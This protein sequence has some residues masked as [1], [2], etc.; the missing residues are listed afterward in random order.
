M[1]KRLAAILLNVLLLLGGLPVF[2]QDE[3]DMTVLETAA[4]VDDSLPARSAILIEQSSGRVLFEK[5]ADEILPPASITKVMTLLLVME[6]LE[7]NTLTLDTMVTCST[8]AASMGGSQIWLKEGEQLSVD[9][10]L[11]ATAISSAND[12]SVAL[13]EQVAGSEEAFVDRMNERA[14]QL[15]MENTHFVNATGLDAEG[16][17]TTARDI[18]TMSR[19]LLNYPLIANYSSVWMT[20]LRGGATQLVNT[21]KLVRF[22]D[23]CTGLKTGTTDGAGSCLAA[24]ATRKGM[25]LVA[26]TLGSPT[27]AERFSAARGLLDYGF[28]NYS[29]AEIPMLENLE[30]VRVRGGI[31]QWVDVVCEP[32]QAVIVRTA[33]KESLTQS[34]ELEPEVQ[35]PVE[36]GQR[37]GK[38]IVQA[39]GNTLCEYRL[40]AATQV[41]EMTFLRAM[42]ILF[43]KLIA[44]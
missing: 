3:V 1:K 16:H 6:A 8:H 19:V 35:A 40:V 36:S 43:E 2:A 24:S 41:Q 5:N 27:S 29:K 20:E 18:A 11:K 10:L 12:A 13:A 4:A 7:Q 25:S 31:E 42:V 23:G 37:L 44:L 38:V 9:D 22:Y 28:S 14:R 39:G 34:V 33:D 15:G 17:V 26:V 30:P 21:N 32:P